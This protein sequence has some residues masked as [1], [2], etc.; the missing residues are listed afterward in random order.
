[1]SSSAAGVRSG[2][3]GSPGSA[4]GPV[5]TLPAS[6][7]A[8]VQRSGATVEEAIA[9]LATAAAQL[10]AIAAA[11]SA[12]G[13]AEEG[14]IFSMQAV[15]AS[16]PAFVAAIHDAAKGGADGAAALIAA[17]EVQAALLA[18]L[19]DEYLAARAADVRDVAS[20][21]ARIL[22]GTTIPLPGRPIILVAEDLPP[23][24]SAEIPREHLLGIA[25]RAGSRT[26]HAVIL[27]RAAGIPCIVAAREL[28]VDGSLD[29][30]KAV[31]DGAAGTLTLAPSS[32][33]LAA[34]DAVKKQGA[35]DATRRATLRGTPC[36]MANGTRVHLYANIGSADGAARAVEV[37]AEGVGLLRSE[38]LLLDRE[39]PPD[40]REQMRAFTKVFEA[41]RAD[42]PLTLR[43]ADIGGDKEIPYLKLP[44][45]A[46]PFLGL[47]G[48]RLAMIKDRPDLR[49]LFASQVA[50]ALR[51]AAATGGALR[52]MAPMISVRAEVDDLLALI[53]AVRAELAARGEAA[54]EYPAAIGVMIE[55][56][57]AALTIAELAAGLDFVSVGTNDLTQYAMAADRINPAL[58]ALQD[59]SAPGVVALLRAVVEGAKKAGVEVG[60]C[61]ELAG[62]VSGA[63]LLTEIGI[64][65]LSM[66]PAAVDEVREGLL[67]A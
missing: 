24:V 59:A 31:V 32:A 19:P 12:A 39:T 67:G 20:R 18:S 35:V 52:I 21:A 5:W 44:H 14:E 57:A 56:P 7:L 13:A 47:R 65:E 42:R 40:E 63:R 27:A 1:M 50:A 38:F 4:A 30:V 22:A 36:V 37:G 61:G 33:D 16:D 29:G 45:E 6:V 15:M 64:Y 49:A 51:A 25:L 58:V 62:S 41:L 34:A 2:T 48:Y 60:V 17:G 11:R 23:S 55:V 66:D 46:N 9:A 28:E 26:A 8:P 53:K 10:T 3:P 54:A 43:L